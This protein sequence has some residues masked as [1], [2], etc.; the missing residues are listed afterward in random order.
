[1]FDNLMT[2]ELILGVSILSV[3]LRGVELSTLRA[4]I[5]ILFLVETIII[6]GYIN[7][8]CANFFVINY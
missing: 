7:T 3:I 1:M 8:G 5:G 2:L 6:G 4:S